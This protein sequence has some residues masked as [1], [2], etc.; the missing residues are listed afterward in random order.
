MKRNIL[1]GIRTT[2]YIQLGNYIGALEPYIRF[3][4]ENPSYRGYVLLADYHSISSVMDPRKLMDYRQHMAAAAMSFCPSSKIFFQSDIP[5]L[6]ELAWILGSRTT[7]GELQRCH[8]YKASSMQCRMSL[9]L[10]SYPV[11]MAADVIGLNADVVSVGVDQAQHIEMAC[12]LARKFKLKSPKALIA[13][14][15]TLIGLDGRKMSKSYENTIPIFA[16]ENDIY[17]LVMK[18]PTT[19]Q[20]IDEKKNSE[21]CTIF[22]LYS[23]IASNAEVKEM[24]DLYDQGIGWKLAK[25]R[26]YIRFMRK[27][28]IER[29]NYS[30]Y[31]KD[32]CEMD[33]SL[34]R[35]AQS[36]REEVKLLLEVIKKD[37]G[38]IS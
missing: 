8:T 2:G 18:I 3:M 23:S 22:S 1:T 35:Q 13:S 12:H 26:L 19:S 32:L 28:E 38:L 7:I 31:S 37:L 5:E 33:L 10:F 9:N 25:E 11:L 14:D 21:D 15:K 27:F 30:L 24:Q 29:A 4:E 34:K 36:V 20:K 17:K 16:S 6:H